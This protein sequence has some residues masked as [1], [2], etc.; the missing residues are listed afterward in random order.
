MDTK[1]TLARLMTDTI[2]SGCLVE[3]PHG[4][5]LLVWVDSESALDALKRM[6]KMWTLENWRLNR[7]LKGSGMRWDP[8]WR[9]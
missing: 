9:N 1:P 7:A 3:V 2:H 5:G 4:A 6:E 8:S